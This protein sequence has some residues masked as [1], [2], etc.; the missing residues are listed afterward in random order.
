[1][2]LTRRHNKWTNGQWISTLE[3]LDPKDQSLWT[4]T[5]RVMRVPTPSPPGHLEGNHYLRL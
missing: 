4:M 1:M 2:S 3:S 5:E